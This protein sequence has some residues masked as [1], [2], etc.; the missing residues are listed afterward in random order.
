MRAFSRNS[1]CPVN[2]IRHLNYNHLFLAKQTGAIK[3]KPE[4]KVAVR[5]NCHLIDFKEIVFHHY[6]CKFFV[7]MSTRT[8][9][10]SEG[11]K[12]A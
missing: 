10:L 7:Q 12:N 5:S 1:F 6:E 8:K 4:R 2:I 9:D 3:L 11:V